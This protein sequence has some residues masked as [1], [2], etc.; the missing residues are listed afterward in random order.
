MRRKLSPRSGNAVLELA[1]SLPVLVGLSLGT[2]QFG[3]AFYM[4]NELEQ[5]VRAGARYAS[6]RD[7]GS[8][9][10]TPDAAYLTAVQNVVVY[11]S[12]EGGKQPVAPGLTTANVVVTM[13]FHN[14]APASVTVAITN[15]RLPQIVGS[16]LLTNKPSTQFPYLGIFAPPAS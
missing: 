14:S 1:L 12:P 10:S 4:Y 3:Y 15:Y 8:F 2:L 5:A 6:L 9:T 16:V 13:A 11:A 7:Y